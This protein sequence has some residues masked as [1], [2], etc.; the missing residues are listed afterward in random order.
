MKKEGEA[1]KEGKVLEDARHED[2]I[3]DQEDTGQS[4]LWIGK[5]LTAPPPFSYK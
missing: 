2:S 1:D 3:N 4:F 5:G